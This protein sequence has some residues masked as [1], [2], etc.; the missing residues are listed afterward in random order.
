MARERET[1]GERTRG[2]GESALREKWEITPPP[3]RQE[4][5]IVVLSGLKK[6]GKGIGEEEER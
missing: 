3:I 1:G 2:I 6:R 5:K 4:K